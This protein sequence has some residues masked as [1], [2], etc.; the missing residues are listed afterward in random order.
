M[1]ER[2][3][4]VDVTGWVADSLVRKGKALMSNERI[5]DEGFLVT[6]F[7]GPTPP[8]RCDFHINTSPEFFYQLRG[9]MRCRILEDG[10]FRDVVVGEGEMFLVPSLVPHLNRRVEG[11]IGLVIHQSRAP[12]VK[13]GIVWYCETC[14]HPLHQEEYVFEDLQRQL[15]GL[16]RRFLGDERLRTCA[17]C[18]TVMPATRGVM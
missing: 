10:R 15:P 6:L 12:G 2:L 11:S 4:V 8:D 16:I 14:C 3:S 5:W 9:E 7:D 18:G 1:R 17:A 13:E